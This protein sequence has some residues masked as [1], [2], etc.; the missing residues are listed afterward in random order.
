MGISRCLPQVTHEHTP[1]VPFC[2]YSPMSH[3]FNINSARSSGTVIVWQSD[4]ATKLDTN[5]I[6]YYPGIAVL[7][8][9]AT[10]LDWATELGNPV[11]CVGPGTK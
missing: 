3:L 6:A 4:T 9:V 1:Y 5:M 10:E 2:K 8:T 7:V 11:Y